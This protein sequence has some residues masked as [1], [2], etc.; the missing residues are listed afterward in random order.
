MIPRIAINTLYSMWPVLILGSVVLITLRLVYLFNEKKKI[1]LYRELIYLSFF[2]YIILLFELVTSTDYHAYGNNFVLFREIFRYQITSPLFL[3]NVVGNVVLFIP[4]GYFVSYFCKIKK[5]YLILIVSFIT[6][7][8]IET[9]QFNIG[10]AFDV[11]DILLNVLGGLMGYGFYLL[12][13]RFLK[14]Y[15]NKFKNH[16]FLNFIFILIIML[17]VLIML[18]VYEVIWWMNFILKTK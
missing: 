14:K 11:D 18:N 7:S 4:F 10:R 5:V 12:S 3:R 17:L 6:S 9:I 1:I 15:P 13:S 16:L 2:I 8:T